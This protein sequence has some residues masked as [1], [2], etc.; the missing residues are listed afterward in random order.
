MIQLFCCPSSLN[1]LDDYMQYY[2]LVEASSPVWNDL[3]ASYILMRPDNHKMIM[4]FF[5]NLKSTNFSNE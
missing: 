5:L 3:F 1:G 2:A 4:S